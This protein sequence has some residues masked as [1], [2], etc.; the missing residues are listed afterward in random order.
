MNLFRICPA[1]IRDSNVMLF[2]SDGERND[3][4]DMLKRTLLNSAVEFH[5]MRCFGARFSTTLPDGRGISVA[6][7]VG[8]GFMLQ[9]SNKS[10][11]DMKM[12]Q[13]SAYVG[14]GVGVLV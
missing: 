3:I 4:A 2:C 13:F 7:Y 9:Y 10:R 6:K 8:T 1:G 5:G 14:V 11:T 12:A